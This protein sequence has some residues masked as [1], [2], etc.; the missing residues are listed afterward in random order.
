MD[1]V[2]TPEP[3]LIP[4]YTGHCPQFRFREGKTYGK[5]SHK[6]LIDPCTKHAPE[7]IVTP[8]TQPTL[9]DYP[10][11]K[12]INI[13]R[14]RI[15]YVDPVYQ[16]PIIPGYDGFIPNM[17][18]KTG[19]RFMA[20]ATA[21]IAEHEALAKLLRC[22]RNLLKHRDILES[23]KGRFDAKLRERMIPSTV[24]RS[25]LIPVKTRGQAIQVD[26]R[27][28]KGE[29]EPYT[30]FT[31]PHFME[32]DNKEKYIVNGYAG[33]IP[34]TMTRFGQSNKQLTNSALCEFTNNYHHRKSDE[35]CPME[36]SGIP[37]SSPNNGQ[38][39]IYHRTIGMVPS[40]AG[41][42]PGELF[43]FGRTYGNSTIDAKNW[44]ALHKD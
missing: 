11:E 18:S 7:L 34:M 10:T 29:K 23:G 12:E 30:K 14:E 32:N 44:L 4:G 43:S 40:Y 3:H 39:V 2:I 20:A 37:S 22:E 1:L 6:L 17:S 33:H 36:M 16:H 41:H 15:Y 25:P 27:E 42:V 5:L 38:F 19:K 35:W 21:G 9:M 24:Y 28:I 31:V 13:L 8:P 26:K